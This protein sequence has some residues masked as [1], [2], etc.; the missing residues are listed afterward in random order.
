MYEDENIDYINRVQFDVDC[1][2]NIKIDCVQYIIF[3]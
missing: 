3:N 2:N 1:K